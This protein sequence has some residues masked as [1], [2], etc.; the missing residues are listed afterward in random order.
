MEYI[1]NMQCRWGS[2]ITL[3]TKLCLYV[4]DDNKLIPY[5]VQC[6]WNSLYSLV[7]D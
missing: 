4:L 7:I 1:D 3:D 6:L 2:P 5:D